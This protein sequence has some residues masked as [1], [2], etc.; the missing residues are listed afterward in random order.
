MKQVFIVFLFFTSFP[1]AAQFEKPKFGEINV[2]DLQMSGYDK[3][4]TAG[5]LI[6]FD[7]GSSDFNLS[8]DREFQISYER[9]IRIKIFKKSA[10][11]LADFT[12]KLY[13]RNGYT[14]SF[15]GFK[16]LTYNLVDGKIVKTKLT[17][18]M[19]YE[20][21]D[22]R[23][24]YK[25]IAFPEVREGSIIEFTYRINSNLLYNFR[26]W[27]FQYNYPALWSQYSYIIPEYFSYRKT[28]KGYLN[29]DVNITK[30]GR[31]TFTV[32]SEAEITPGMGGGRTPGEI[33]NLDTRSQEFILGVKDVPAFIPE[34]DIDCE[35][36]YI[37]SIEFELNTVRIE[38]QPLKDYT[39]T[40]EAVNEDMLSDLDFGDLLNSDG[41]VR[42]TVAA[43][44][45]GITSETD[46]AALIY[47]YLQ[48][49]MK[50]TGDYSLWAVK[51]LK[52]PYADRVGNSSEINLIL[53]LMLRNA[54]LK[55]D[56]VVF[57]TRGNGI[58]ITYFPTISKFNSVLVQ[59][60][61]EGKVYLIDA[62]NK[63][64]PFGI[65]PPND[66]N[67][68]G[69]VINNKSGDWAQLEPNEKYSES[70]KYN[71]EITADG[72][73]N[74][75]VTGTYNGYAGIVYRNLLSTENSID[76]YFRKIQENS[77]GLTITSYKV[78]DLRDLT[79]PLKDTIF[80]KIDDNV[81]NIGDKILFN[82]M[83]YERIE[84][85]RYNLEK[86]SYPVDFTYPV[87]RKYIFTYSIPE[88]YKVESLP[89]DATYSSSDK[90]I[91]FS[92]SV[93][94]VDNKI[95]IEYKQEIN[96]IVFPTSE[97]TILKNL[98]DQI[99]NKHA[100]QIILKKSS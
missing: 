77:K 86:R 63:Y 87:S 37:Q 47:Y 5:A 81:E 53:T 74:G 95:T 15:A 36:N 16:G 98:Y 27:T 61:A 66:L 8:P 35:D 46:K 26:G 51:G 12:I 72:I 18:D 60:Q 82:P 41:W 43:I 93:Q 3:D 70:K 34:P 52:K 22:K 20:T 31:K 71:L 9:H 30:D 97:Y 11:G 4:T 78:A 49:R 1:L 59:L 96:K 14:E 55:A 62:I 28:A 29:F 38:N 58:P 23:Y 89:K 39:T 83:L 42:D 79:K 25:R 100:E 24:V 21:K 67:S 69:R 68:R 84:K 73:I 76:D 6:L 91:S 40:W 85:N 64:C 94:T 17:N 50:W 44:C 88:G 80:V 75:I 19:I 2:S 32:R 90:S 7:D 57:S 33:Y 10:E 45:K 65:L 54:G 48:K 92:Y 56:P 99:V 13:Q